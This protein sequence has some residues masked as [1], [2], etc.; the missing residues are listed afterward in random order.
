MHLI[1]DI[2]I[3]GPTFQ[4]T[5]GLA[6]AAQQLRELANEIERNVVDFSDCREGQR[7]AGT[8]GGCAIVYLA[9]L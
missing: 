5:T 1:V 9:D 4:G 8:N 2:D 3:G 6:E 7:L